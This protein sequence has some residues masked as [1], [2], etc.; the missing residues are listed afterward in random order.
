MPLPVVISLSLRMLAANRVT[1][2]PRL[3]A[4]WNWIAS[5]RGSWLGYQAVGKISWRTPLKKWEQERLGLRRHGDRRNQKRTLF[6]FFAAVGVYL[7]LFY[8]DDCGRVEQD[9]KA[10]DKAK[11]PSKRCIKCYYLGLRWCVKGI[12]KVRVLFMV[13][14]HQL[15]IGTEWKKLLFT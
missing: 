14:C 6:V 15:A 13:A 2:K 8:Q 9:V 5:S 12:L 10:D 11:P 1:L 4:C 7:Y 3:N